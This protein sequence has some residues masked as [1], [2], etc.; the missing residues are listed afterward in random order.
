MIDYD[1]NPRAFDKYIKLFNEPQ[2][3]IETALE[4]A[5]A[6]TAQPAIDSI[7]NAPRPAVHPFRWSLDP[8]KQA[9]ARRWYFAAIKRGEINT[10]GSHYVRSGKYKKSFNVAVQP[11]SDGIDAVFG[12]NFNKASFI[13]GNEDRTLKQ[14]P[15]H[16]TTGWN[17]FAPVADKWVDDTLQALEQELPGII[18]KRVD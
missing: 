18:K 17:E 1:A 16:E 7:G 2:I 10:N 4:L 6:K 5:I 8:Q 3:V 11:S 9:K 15:G 12:S 13:A 14:I